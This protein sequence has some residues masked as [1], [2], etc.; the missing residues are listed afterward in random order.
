MRATYNYVYENK[1]LELSIRLKAENDK[2]L[3][4]EAS[5][6]RNESAIAAQRKIVIGLQLELKKHHVRGRDEI[7]KF[8]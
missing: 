8:T 2:L 3:K 7:G 1:P 6:P 5:R 4:L